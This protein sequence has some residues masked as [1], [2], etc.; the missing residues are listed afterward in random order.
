VTGTARHDR[1]EGGHLKSG[2]A[3][4]RPSLA[5][6]SSRLGAAAPC[7]LYNRGVSLVDCV[8]A[9]WRC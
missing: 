2:R 1:R 5:R 8:E 9:V 7:R 3:C 4:I 6:R